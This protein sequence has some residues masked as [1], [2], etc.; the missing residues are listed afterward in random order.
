[1]FGTHCKP[2]HKVCLRFLT[3]PILLLVFSR[4]VKAMT[5][6]LTSSVKKWTLEEMVEPNVLGSPKKSK[7]TM[8]MEWGF[9]GHLTQEELAVY[10]STL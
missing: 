2:I 4:Y 6:D 9:P 1:M 3:L 5:D 8:A 10:V 7:K